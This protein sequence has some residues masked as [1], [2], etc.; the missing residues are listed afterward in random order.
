MSDQAQRLEA[1]ETNQSV[2]V[3]APAGSGK[4]ELLVSR[5]LALLADGQ[6]HPFQIY[7]ITFTRK[8][9]HEM[10]HRIET[11][12]NAASLNLEV[13]SHQQTSY[14][15]AKRVLKRSDEL[16]WNILD[17]MDELN[18][19]TIDALTQ[20]LVKYFNPTVSHYSLATYPYMVYQQACEDAI[21]AA[22]Q[23][24]DTQASL[25]QLLSML[26]NNLN[27]LMDLSCRLLASRDQWLP[28]LSNIRSHHLNKESITTALSLW[29]DNQ[30]QQCYQ[31][32]DADMSSLLGQYLR[33]TSQ[34]N[35]NAQPYF[36]RHDWEQ[37]H[38]LLVTK[39]GS[40]RKRINPTCTKDLTLDTID[41]IKSLHQCCIEAVESDPTFIED[42]KMIVSLPD[43]KDIDQQQDMMQALSFW[44]PS[45]AAHLNLYFDQHETSDYIYY[46]LELQRL[47]N[48]QP[49]DDHSVFS[50]HQKVRHLLIDEFQDTSQ[51]QY[52]LL[53]SLT[54]N[55]DISEQTLFLVG[56]PMQSIYRF[57]K[58]EVGLFYQVRDHGLGHIQPKFIELKYNFRSKPSII[59][60]I[61]HIFSSKVSHCGSFGQHHVPFVPSLAGQAHTDT[62]TSVH[63]HWITTSHPHDEFHYLI[64]I[65]RRILDK[66][67]NDD[68]A[69]LTRSR[70]QIEPLC[71]L[72]TNVGIDYVGEDLIPM[73]R[74]QWLRDLIAATVI[75][76]HPSDNIA[77][78][79]VLTCQSIVGM[80]D[81][82]IDHIPWIG[83]DTSRDIDPSYL[84][85]HPKLG[86]FMSIYLHS[87]S[88]IGFANLSDTLRDYWRQIGLL[89]QANHVK[90]TLMN[91]L[92]SMINAMVDHRV[93]IKRETILEHLEQN[94]MSQ[95]SQEPSSIYIM[96]I[97]KA[98]GLEFD[99]VLLPCLHKKTRATEK[100]D[101]YLETLMI[102]DRPLTLVAPKIIDNNHHRLYE[103]IH[104]QHQRKDQAEGDRLFYV[105]C[106][107]AKKSLHMSAA[108]GSTI[109]PKSST[110][111]LAHLIEQY[112]NFIDDI[113]Q[114]TT[115]RSRTTTY[116]QASYFF[117]K[118]SIDPP[119]AELQN[120][121]EPLVTQ[122][123][124]QGTICHLII[125]LTQGCMD[126][127]KSL[128]SSLIYVCE[129]KIDHF[130]H[131]EH[132]PMVDTS[133]R[134]IFELYQEPIMQW[135]L[136]GKHHQRRFETTIEQHE[137][138]SNPIN[139]RPD[140]TFVE[141]KLRTWIVDFKLS[142]LSEDQLFNT[143][144]GQISKY[145]EVIDQDKNP[146]KI[147]IGCLCLLQQKKLIV[148]QYPDHEPKVFDCS[149][150]LK[151][152]IL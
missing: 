132:A 79:Q 59:N 14:K 125:E 72:M 50:L 145:A 2:M 37:L 67:P 147:I 54:R 108:I 140:Y 34:T 150:S 100:K 13:K 97:H 18:F 84:E 42:L 134:I 55:W 120:L 116:H 41:D 115:N 141:K 88:T 51:S 76:F 99:H 105:A 52:Q 83:N 63:G 10:R 90:M 30:L 74:S 129:H 138:A 136:S 139:L 44:L 70:S 151:E 57:R 46:N 17:C 110:S 68:I 35:T 101:L 64:S 11:I 112:P 121:F 87:H 7:A 135:L 6:T 152:I 96:T 26:D 31:R 124:L 91:T 128:K 81:D 5:F 95:P 15:L 27:H 39:S 98:K 58:A 32:L 73:Q 12:L 36:H 20:S 75:L 111:Q 127:L 22:E 29:V 49:Q 103:F 148:W 21:Q 137:S 16:G 48:H 133:W 146:E 94:H 78:Y 77:W 8:A 38:Q 43:Y 149:E 93:T 130:W 4:T 122:Q 40:L 126:K 113:K 89:H 143:Y 144:Q 71:Q 65:V 24:V 33:L 142:G 82:A 86:L 107:R 114:Q 92:L 9:Q 66:H 118:I 123:Q 106:T 109:P 28:Y 69:I 25:Q 3:Q 85:K 131:V 1:L 80:S 104:Q 62:S 56:D 60:D 19:M 119:T 61:N 117:E 47:L 45:I 102:N 23:S 53:L